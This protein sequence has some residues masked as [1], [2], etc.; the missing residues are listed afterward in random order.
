MLTFVVKMQQKTI[1]VLIFVVR[2]KIVIFKNIGTELQFS[3]K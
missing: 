3:K 2:G 1:R